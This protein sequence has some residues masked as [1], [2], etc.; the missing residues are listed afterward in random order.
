MVLS[1]V[2]TLIT[3]SVQNILN[4]RK[5]IHSLQLEEKKMD[6]AAAAM[7]HKIDLSLRKQLKFIDTHHDQYSMRS[8]ACRQQLAETDRDISD[9][10]AMV[11]EIAMSMIEPHNSAEDMAIFHY[12]YRIVS[13]RLE[14]LYSFRCILLQQQT[15]LFEELRNALQKQRC[16][17]QYGEE[18]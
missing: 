2:I 18:S 12:Q 9:F 14:S 5:E 10:Q 11:R 13:E 1:P 3:S 16:R 15:S 8:E 4:I 17:L 7:A 6:L